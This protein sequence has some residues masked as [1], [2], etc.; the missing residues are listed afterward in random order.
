MSQQISVDRF[1][2][3][4]KPELDRLEK[5][6]RHSQFVGLWKSRHET[7]FAGEEVSRHTY[8]SHGAHM[9]MDT[10]VIQRREKSNRRWV[11][12]S[13]VATPH[14]AFHASRGPDEGF[15]LRRFARD[16]QETDNGIRWK[17]P[18]ASSTY[19]YRNVTLWDFLTD[20][21]VEITKCEATKRNGERVVIV[22]CQKEGVVPQAF[23]FST[24]K[25]WALVD[26]WAGED[27]RRARIEVQYEMV[28]GYPIVRR[29]EEYRE[30][31]SG[32]VP[33]RRVVEV[34]DFIPAPAP[35]DYFDPSSL[36][37]HDAMPAKDFST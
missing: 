9:R 1:L 16:P 7:Q 10:L 26:F 32:H 22:H 2:S 19:Q 27:D 33:F 24:D 18:F 35:L 23:T 4:V 30:Y 34:S 25:S 20:P 5:F 17:Y 8:R 28:N 37:I 31:A 13:R 11:E 14:M 21:S 6:Y 3:A 36:G 15:V 12:W 29:F